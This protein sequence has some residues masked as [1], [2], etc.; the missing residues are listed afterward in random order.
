MTA[1]IRS[2]DVAAAMRLR[3]G[4]DRDAALAGLR[5]EPRTE[6]VIPEPVEDAVREGEVHVADEAAVLFHQ[7]VERTVPEP[8]L[9]GIRLGRFVAASLQRRL[10]LCS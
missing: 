7:R 5:I 3:V 2:G 4:G 1:A 9:T 10:Q 6:A 8:D